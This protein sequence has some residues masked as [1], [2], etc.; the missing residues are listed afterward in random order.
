MSVQSNVENEDTQSN[1][2]RM[3][4][5]VEPGI[6]EKLRELAGGRFKMG[7]WLSQLIEQMHESKGASGAVQSME[8]EGLRLMCLGMGGQIQSLRGELAHLQSQLAAII[9]ANQKEEQP[10]QRTSK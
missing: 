1:F 5:N 10:D 7:S 4:L 3:N 8:I 2:V 9:A 6:P